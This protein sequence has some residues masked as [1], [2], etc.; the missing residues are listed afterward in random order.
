MIYTVTLK[1][2]NSVQ[3]FTETLYAQ[4]FMELWKKMFYAFL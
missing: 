4:K 1:M 3:T 2:L